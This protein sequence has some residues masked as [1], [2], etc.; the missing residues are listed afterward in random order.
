MADVDQIECNTRAFEDLKTILAAKKIPNALLFYGRK[1]TRKKEAAFFFSKGANCNEKGPVPCDQCGPCRKIQTDNHPDIHAIKLIEGKKN[2]AIS[3][4][5]DMAMKLSNKPNE[6]RVRVVMIVD[7]ELMNIQAQNALLKLL[8]EPPEKT[9]FILMVQKETR[10]LPTVLSRCRK[11]LFKPLTQRLVE[12]QLIHAYKIDPETARIAAGTADSDLSKTLLWLNPETDKPGSMDWAKTRKWLIRHLVRLVETDK[13]GVSNGLIL[14]EKLCRS[15]EHIDDIIAVIKSFL[16]DLI[17]FNFSPEK[18][19]NLDFSDSFANIIQYRGL[20][21]IF[22]WQAA[23][24]ETE[25]R[26]IS[27]SGLR[28]TMDQFF[29]KLACN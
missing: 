14:S 4:I 16:R 26:L 12:H 10:L 24:Y 17:V 1:N 5:R 7:A 25:K 22:F 21:K 29:L 23:L 18:I 9:C 20:E 8:E 3:Q 11:I 19:V 6:A 27:N 28:L 15:P 13:M 2:I